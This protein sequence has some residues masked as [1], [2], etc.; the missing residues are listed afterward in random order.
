MQDF[1]DFD[2]SLDASEETNGLRPEEE[3]CPR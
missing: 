1:S 3:R 2:V